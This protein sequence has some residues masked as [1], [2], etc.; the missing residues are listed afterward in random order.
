MRGRI[1]GWYNSTPI[2]GDLSSYEKGVL[3]TL[4]ATHYTAV[5]HLYRPSPNNPSPSGEQAAEMAQAAVRM[6]HLYQ[7]FFRRHMLSIYWRS[8]ENIFSAGT[9]LMLAYIQFPDVREVITLSSLESLIHTCSS[10][11]WGMVERFPSFQGKRD[12]FDIAASKALEE[13]KTTASEVAGSVSATTPGSFVAGQSGYL[14]ALPPVG[15]TATS[16]SNEWVHLMSLVLTFFANIFPRHDSWLQFLTPDDF[17]YHL[18][19]ESALFQDLD[20]AALL[21]NIPA[22]PGAHFH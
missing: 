1:D 21:G 12:A 6:I 15:E 19:Q 13:P 16:Q 20:L 5:F 17:T 11:L 7:R 2:H 3:E 14:S 22:T 9:A 18:D 10:L 4:E 8:I